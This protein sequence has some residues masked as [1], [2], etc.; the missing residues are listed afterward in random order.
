MCVQCTPII[1][2]RVFSL[3]R[4]HVSLHFVVAYNF[5]RGLEDCVIL[6]INSHEAYLLLFTHFTILKMFLE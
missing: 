6:S 2:P 4:R 3:V 1:V 5:M